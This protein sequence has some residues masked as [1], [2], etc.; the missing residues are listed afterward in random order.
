MACENPLSIINPRYKKMSVIERTEY[1]RLNFGCDFP[2]DYQIEVPC[3]RCQY[4]EKH[5]M[6]DFQ[7][8]LLYEI[9]KYPNS[10]FITL[11]FDD[12]N[13]LRFSANP[14]S[15][16]RLF[17]DRV[18]KRYGKQVRHWIVAEYGTLHGRLH[19][20]GIL[21]DTPLRLDGDELSRLWSYGFSYVGYSC[22]KTARYVTKYVT[23]SCSGN[24]SPPRII[25]SKG[26]GAGYLTPENVLF[27][28]DGE[29]LRPY[30]YYGGF[31]V[32]LP[33]YYYSK[34]FSDEDK[35]R[36]LLERTECPQPKILN[37]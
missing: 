32:P 34:V 13:L 16:V 4:C 6:R 12:T 5:R 20:H 23:K 30:L 29:T 25:S 9:D 7:I 14:N 2:I 22:D 18:R 24:R 17:L 15:A 37:G 21:F 36:M 26:I 19:Y 31:K 11:T 28:N 3:G 27:H 10:L 33:R 8:R 35:V 1:S